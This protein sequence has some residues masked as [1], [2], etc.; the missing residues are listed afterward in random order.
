MAKTKFGVEQKDKAPKWED[1][2]ERE[3]IE[4]LRALIVGVVVFFA[5]AAAAVIA[6]AAAADAFMVFLKIEAAAAAVVA[7]FP[8]FLHVSSV[9]KWPLSLKGFSVS[10]KKIWR[11]RECWCSSEV[12]TTYEKSLYAI[13]G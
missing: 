9:Q 3:L 13:C 5:F 8:R 4:T 7:V 10:S 12:G 1:Q 11:E 6:F 2:R